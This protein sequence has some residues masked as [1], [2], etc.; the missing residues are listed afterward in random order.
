MTGGRAELLTREPGISQ[1]S[2]VLLLREEGGELSG[3]K[4]GVLFP[5]PNPQKQRRIGGDA[6]VSSPLLAT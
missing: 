5:P 1:G 3:R 2:R 4:V 6:L